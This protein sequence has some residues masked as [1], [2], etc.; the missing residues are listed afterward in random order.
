MSSCFLDAVTRAT[1][2][3]VFPF[4]ILIYFYSVNNGE[5]TS[6]ENA[7]KHYFDTLRRSL[8]N[9]D[10]KTSKSAAIL[11]ILLGTRIHYYL[12]R[13]VFLFDVS[14]NEFGGF[15]RRKNITKF[16]CL[17]WRVLKRTLYPRFSTTETWDMFLQQNQSTNMVNEKFFADHKRVR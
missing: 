10:R 12:E 17:K 14:N 15:R 11:N 2:K 16:L 4:Y 1:T 5:K 7:H 6:G 8:E 3:S 9:I 13:G